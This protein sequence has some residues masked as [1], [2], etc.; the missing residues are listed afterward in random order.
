MIEQSEEMKERGE[1]DFMEAEEE[2][3]YEEKGQKRKR[4]MN[5]IQYQNALHY[6]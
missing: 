6:F 2:E 4:S 1:V 3:V 5:Y